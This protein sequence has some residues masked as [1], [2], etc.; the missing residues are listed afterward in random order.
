[1][2][3]EHASVVELVAEVA[4]TFVGF[5]LVIGLLQPHDPSASRRRQSMRSVAELGLIA[6]GGAM[7]A[8]ALD[9]FG[10]DPE[11]VWRAASIVTALLWVALHIVA[12]RRFKTAG[13]QITRT[14][15]LRIAA[16]LAFIGMGLLLWNAMIPD[17]YSGSRYIASLMLALTVSA[18]LFLLETFGDTNDQNAA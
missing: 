14:R 13:S 7:L 11:D 5:S 15:F 10:L 9:T 1:M 16:S 17:A 4:A 18:F 6:A 8:L 2:S 12:S 3:I